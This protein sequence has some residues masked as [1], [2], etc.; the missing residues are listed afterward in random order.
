MYLVRTLLDL[1]LVK[2]GEGFGNRDHST[3]IHSLR[4]VEA[5]LEDDEEFRSRVEAARADLLGR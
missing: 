5:R 4:K 3:V 2:I 1:S